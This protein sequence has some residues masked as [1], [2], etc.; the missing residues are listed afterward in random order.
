MS[1][2]ILSLAV[3]KANWEAK[4]AGYIDNFNV[5]IAECLRRSP[6][7]VVSA[8]AIL[9]A[10]EKNFGL[11][12]P[13]KTVNLVLRRAGKT[14]LVYRALGVYHIDR[15][16][17]EK[18]RF[19]E[20]RNKFISSYDRLIADLRMYAEEKYSKQKN[21]K[22]WSI[23]DAERTLH[24]YLSSNSLTLFRAIT[25]K[26]YIP[27][28]RAATPSQ[29][30][31]FGSYVNSLFE[32]QSEHLNSLQIVLEGHMLA[33][34]IFLPDP[35]STGAKFQNTSL[36]FDTR[37]LMYALGYA[38]ESLEAPRKELLVMVYELGADL[39]CFEHTADEMI[40]ILKG[41]AKNLSTGSGVL[42]YGPSFDYFLSRGFNESDVLFLAGRLEKELQRIRIEIK[43]K[44]AYADKHMIDEKKLEACISSKLTYLNPY[45][46]HRD[47]DS[48]SAIPRIRA[49]HQ[50]NLVERCRA[51]FVTSNTPL[52]EA[53]NEF[54]GM[55]EDSPLVPLA[56]SDWDL[57]NLTW[58]KK[59]LKAPDLPRKRL[60]ADCYGAVQPSD[61]FR[62]SLNRELERYAA[63]NGCTPDDVYVLRHSLE[64]RKLALE[65]TAGDENAFTEGTV[66]EVLELY[67]QRILSEE[68]SALEAAER[69]AQQLEEKIRDQTAKQAAIN[70][71]IE[72]R[73]VSTARKLSGIVLVF[74][75]VLASTTLYFT[76]S[77]GPELKLFKIPIK[78][79]A[80]GA[81]FVWSLVNWGWGTTLSRIRRHIEIKMT[82]KLEI[83]FKW[84]GGM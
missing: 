44:P 2:T 28:P 53:V 26:T 34:A 47:I 30:Y 20:Y 11:R 42:G 70:A 36:F 46:L 74:L 58:L 38:G 13:L 15:V 8:P 65:L 83:L 10:L 57:T 17:V 48:I 41:C 68:R 55:E 52:V 76:I 25:K 40:S 29:R 75:L 43:P 23:E 79:L 67:R 12:L 50:A 18:I 6:D 66:Q 73:A 69:H 35:S 64:V 77:S 78:Y 82:S 4:H 19:E 80:T 24:D 16:E 81:L 61:R 71:E 37:F 59:P 45:A 72:K 39:C 5:L 22:K 31:I 56:I 63:K 3:L 27:L 21:W 1:D 51:I 84:M 14:G 7:D 9:D 54:A 62:S 60:L 32:L 33:T 49:G